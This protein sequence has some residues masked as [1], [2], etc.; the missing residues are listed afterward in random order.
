[1]GWFRHCHL[2]RRCSGGDCTDN[3]GL[4]C[5]C[6]G[7]SS[8]GAG[9]SGDGGGGPGEDGAVWVGVGVDDSKDGAASENYGG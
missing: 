3:I 6:S 5:F 7:G 9:E 1:M 4:H 8:S 2:Q